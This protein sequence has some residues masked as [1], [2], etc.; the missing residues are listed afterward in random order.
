MIEQMTGLPDDTLGFSA[1]GMVTAEDYER[2]LMPAVEDV[3]SRHKK[4]RVLYHLGEEFEGFEFGALWDDAKIGFK[5]P[6]SWHRVAVV[7]DKGWVRNLTKGIGFF[8]LGHLRVFPNSELE[9]ART[10]LIEGDET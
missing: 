10:W 2:V 9:P 3:L 8:L 6:L 7:T 1:K 5:Y 4:M